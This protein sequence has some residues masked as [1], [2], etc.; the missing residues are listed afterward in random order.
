MNNWV[1]MDGKCFNLSA[2]FFSLKRRKVQWIFF[3]ESAKCLTITQ[4]IRRVCGWHIHRYETIYDLRKIVTNFW[5][6]TSLNLWA[7]WKRKKSQLVLCNAD[8]IADDWY[9]NHP[10]YISISWVNSKYR[11]LSLCKQCNKL[12]NQCAVWIFCKTCPSVRKWLDN[13]RNSGWT[14]LSIDWNL[15]NFLFVSLLLPFHFVRLFV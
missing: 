6:R 12:Q 14:V 8:A 9:T 15:W 4:T 11:W 1:R 10:E 3:L 5:R 13:K 2:Y 7:N